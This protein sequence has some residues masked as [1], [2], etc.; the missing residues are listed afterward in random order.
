M[1]SSE[2]IDYPGSFRTARNHSVAE[3][4]VM[5]LAINSVVRGYHVYKDFWEAATGE[6]LRCREERTNIH[7][8]FAVAIIYKR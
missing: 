3:Y 1:N 8:P 5:S 7:D 4:L 6:I 2:S